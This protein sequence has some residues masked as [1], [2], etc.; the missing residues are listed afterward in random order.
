M[1]TI[2]VSMYQ[3]VVTSMAQLAENQ[4]VAALHVGDSD[5]QQSGQGGDVPEAQHAVEVMTV[6]QSS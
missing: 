1:V 4:Q 6:D 2:P 3:T 5:S